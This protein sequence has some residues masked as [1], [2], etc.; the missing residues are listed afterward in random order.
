MINIIICSPSSP[1][2][3]GAVT[4][5]PV[6]N[7][8]LPLHFSSSNSSNSGLPGGGGGR[9]RLLLPAREAGKGGREEDWLSEGGEKPRGRLQCRH[10]HRGVS[11]HQVG[12]AVDVVVHLGLAQHQLQHHSQHSLPSSQ[13]RQRQ[14]QTTTKSKSF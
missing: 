2:A 12:L 9:P 10:R 11:G 13:V 7:L 3:V 6:V 5:S 1:E 14:K 4:I 8:G